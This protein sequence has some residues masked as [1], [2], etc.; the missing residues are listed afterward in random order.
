MTGSARPLLEVAVHHARDVRGAVEG[1]A[2]RLALVA[3]GEHAALSPDVP[4]ASAVIRSSEVPVRVLLRLDESLSV[5]GGQFVRLVGLAKEYLELGAE[6]VVM[7]FLDADLRVDVDT[8]RAFADALPGVPWTFHRAVDRVLEPARAWHALVGLPGL[9]AVRTAGSARGLAE[10]YDDLLAL[11]RGDA[12][13]ARLAMP[14][15]GLAPEHVP[16]FLRAGV[17]QVHLGPQARP[18]GSYRA[19]VDAG[20]VRSWR[21]MLDEESARLGPGRGGNAR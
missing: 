13:I 10:G 19:Y 15:G 21:R 8:C 4:T 20:F 16:W 3:P 18:G 6:G 5:T 11:V 1:G 14:G 2:D 7:G 12:A 9:D 17:R